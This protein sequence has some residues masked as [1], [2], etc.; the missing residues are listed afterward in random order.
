MNHS[1]S[2][3]AALQRSKAERGSHRLTEAIAAFESA[4]PPYDWVVNSLLCVLQVVLYQRHDEVSQRDAVT[5]QGS[6]HE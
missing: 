5:Q 2:S 3:R 6:I 4:G 1:H